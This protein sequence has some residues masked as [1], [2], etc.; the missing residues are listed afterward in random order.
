MQLNLNN[1]CKKQVIN[2][3]CLRNKSNNS[4]DMNKAITVFT[5]V[6]LMVSCSVTSQD[7]PKE[8]KTE[9]SKKQK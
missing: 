9:D 5:A 8:V 2:Y 4:Q 1:T 7:T 6:G 3:F